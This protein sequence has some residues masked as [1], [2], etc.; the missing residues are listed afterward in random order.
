VNPAVRVILADREGAA[1]R[2]LTGLLSGLGG[3]VLAEVAGDLTELAV[4]LRKGS[5]DV[6][7]IDDRLLGGLGDLGSAAAGLRVLVLGVDDDPAFAAR[8]GRLGAEEWIAKDRA[9]E[10]LAALLAP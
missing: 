4:A 6:L 7:V 5:A 9:D 2:A 1:R 3:V 10:R 8:A